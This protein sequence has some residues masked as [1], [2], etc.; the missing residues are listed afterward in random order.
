MS[1]HLTGATALATLIGLASV[2]CSG[3]SAPATLLVIKLM[4]SQ[5]D[6]LK[7]LTSAQ[8]HITGDS[9]DVRTTDGNGQIKIELSPGVHT[10]H[11]L[12]QNQCHFDVKLIPGK[13]LNFEVMVPQ[14]A[15]NVCQSAKISETVPTSASGASNASSSSGAASKSKI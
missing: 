12:T 14:T 9:A 2:P 15:T 11:L 13:T 4:V 10:V 7:P 3:E 1:P 8:L 5:A 6:R